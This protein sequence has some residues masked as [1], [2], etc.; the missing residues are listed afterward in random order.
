MRGSVVGLVLHDFRRARGCAPQL[1]RRGF[2][3]EE[4]TGDGTKLH[5]A[6]DAG[7]CEK[8]KFDFA[9]GALPQ[10]N[11]YLCMAQAVITN[12]NQS[13]QNKT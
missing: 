10:L 1:S 6:G 7:R 13:S 11:K 9:W 5:F 2:S 8:H 3:D 12:N 4:S